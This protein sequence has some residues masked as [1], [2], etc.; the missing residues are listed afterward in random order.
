MLVASAKSD[1]GLDM[2]RIN[3][4]YTAII[5]RSKNANFVDPTDHR[6]SFVLFPNI[7]EGIACLLAKRGRIFALG[8]PLNGANGAGER[9]CIR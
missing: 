6:W 8:Y 3:T 7:G 5:A 2:Y 1:F 4:Y 9:G